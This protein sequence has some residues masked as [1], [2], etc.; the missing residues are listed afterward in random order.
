MAVVLDNDL[1]VRMAGRLDHLTAV[2][3]GQ[4]S[5]ELTVG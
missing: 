2:T 3:K 1:A 4:Q 5:A